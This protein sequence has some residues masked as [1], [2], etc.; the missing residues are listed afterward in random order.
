MKGHFKIRGIVIGATFVT[1]STLAVA[2]EPG[3]SREDA[4]QAGIQGEN[5]ILFWRAIQTTSMQA[6]FALI[7]VAQK[8]GSVDTYATTAKFVVGAI[9]MEFHIPYSKRGSARAVAIA[10]A[11]P[12]QVF[13]FKSGAA[14]ANITRY[15]DE[16]VLTEARTALSRYS[17]AELLSGFSLRGQLHSIYNQY[18]H[19]KAHGY[20]FAVAHVLLERGLLPSMHSRIGVTE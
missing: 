7:H 9:H 1:L 11:T 15:Y 5:N 16:A 19:P 3:T 6:P 2:S 18:Q 14:R 17:N 4:L 12:G 10:L 20:E 13:N 8:D